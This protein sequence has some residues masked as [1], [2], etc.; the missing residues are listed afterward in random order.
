MNKFGLIISDIT[1]RMICLSHWRKI[2]Q[3]KSKLSSY[4]KKSLMVKTYFSFLQKKHA[5]FCNFTTETLV[6]S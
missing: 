5:D 3:T 2:P 6:L 1:S 4:E